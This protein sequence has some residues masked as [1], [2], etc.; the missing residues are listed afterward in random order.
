VTYYDQLGLDPNADS[1]QIRRA[2]RRLARLLH[3]DRCP[4]DLSRLDAETRMKRLNEIAAV[5]LD[6]VARRDYDRR[7]LLPPA[8]PPLPPAR[9]RHAR[10]PWIWFAAC[11]LCA[12]ALAWFFAA[13]AARFDRPPASVAAAPAPAEQPLPAAQPGKQPAAART[14]R[15]GIKPGPAP[16]EP[17]LPPPPSLPAAFQLLPA[18][19]AAPDLPPGPPPARPTPSATAAD[20]RLHSPNTPAASGFASP[21]AATAADAQLRSP[22]TPAAAPRAAFAGTWLYAPGSAEAP[23][24]YPPAYIE[25]T[26]TE[27][28]STLRG[29]YRGRY[30]VTDRTISPSVSFRFEGPAGPGELLWY[31]PGGARGRVK[32]KLKDAQSLEVDWWATRLGT[33]MGLAA[34]KAVLVRLAPQP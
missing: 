32:L 2:Y 25:L 7:L 19:A 24:L 11:L 12:A 16:A 1:A 22:N 13:S 8:L 17:V 31:G 18:P 15:P 20:A 21:P 23:G 28:G 30:R 14:P 10:A 33:E 29:L 6:P 34:G 26:I 3:P 4:D 5:L 9:L 27:D